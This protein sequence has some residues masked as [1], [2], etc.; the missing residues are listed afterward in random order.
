[1]MIKFV[2]STIIANT[3]AT[4][5]ERVFLLA[6][7][8]KTPFTFFGRYGND[9]PVHWEIE[10]KD[11]DLML[12]HNALQHGP[13]ELLAIDR[14][15]LQYTFMNRIGRRPSHHAHIAPRVSMTLDSDFSRQVRLAILIPRGEQHYLIVNS[16]DPHKICPKESLEFLTVNQENVMIAA[17]SLHN[18]ETGELL[19]PIPARYHPTGLHI[20]GDVQTSVPPYVFET[21]RDE[22]NKFG[23]SAEALTKLPKVKYSID[24][25]HVTK[26]AYENIFRYNN[27]KLEVHMNPADY[28][29][30]VDGVCTFKIHSHHSRHAWGRNM[31]SKFIFIIDYNGQRYGICGAN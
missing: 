12:A 5:S 21:L 3:A 9:Q 30:E 2:F 8:Q 23:C 19:A 24:K 11:R 4:F 20:S 10:F 28:V 31:L 27:D 26:N 6:D 17:I 15:L 14:T 22:V 29:E 18:Q 16:P 13:L 25:L 1:M 7:N